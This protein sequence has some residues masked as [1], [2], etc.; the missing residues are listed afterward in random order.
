MLC[1]HHGLSAVGEAVFCKL[2][3]YVFAAKS[4]ADT[5]RA[6]MDQDV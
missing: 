6:C 2:V 5:K 1:V 3:R 4:I